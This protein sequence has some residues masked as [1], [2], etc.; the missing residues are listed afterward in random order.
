MKNAKTVRLKSK[1][2]N[3]Q[4]PKSH[5]WVLMDALVQGCASYDDSIDLSAFRGAIRERSTDKLFDA[6]DRWGPQCIAFSDG[7]TPDLFSVKYQLSAFLKKFPFPG[8]SD[9]RTATALKG[10]MEAE[11][12]CGDYNRIARKSFAAFS[13]QDEIMQS[14]V[15]IMRDFIRRVLGDSVELTAVTEFARHGPG[16][17]FVTR[18]GRVT[19]Y[20][21]YSDLPYTVT[22]D[23]QAYARLLIENDERWYGALQDRYRNDNGIPIWAPISDDHLFGWA[24]EVIPGNRITF[25]PKD[26]RKDRPIAIEPLMNLM[27]QLG[28]DG[29]LRKRLKR[30]G[31]NLDSQRKNQE[32]ALLGSLPGSELRFSTID[33]S[34]ASDSVSKELC[35]ELLPAEWFSYLM[36]LRSP[37]GTVT[38]SEP[39]SLVYEK[40]SSMGNGFTF[41]LES[42]IF[43]AVAYAAT[44]LSQSH[45]VSMHDISVYGDDIIVPQHAAL[46]CIELLQRC[47][48]STNVDKTY[49]VGP[50][51][52]SCGMDYFRGV[53]VRPLF[54]T[55][56]IKDVKTLFSVTN[57]LAFTS[58]RVFG[59]DSHP[60]LQRAIEICQG[61]IPSR[62]KHF[63]GP[64]SDTEF[65]TYLHTPVSRRSKGKFKYHRG[66]Y[67]FRR[68]IVLPI[69]HSRH[70]KEFLFR[71]LMANLRDYEVAIPEWFYRVDPK[72]WILLDDISRQRNHSWERKVW[73]PR[74]SGGS[75]FT[76]T[77]RNALTVAHVEST[78]S[79]WMENYSDV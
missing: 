51:R 46:L 70:A 53:L 38:V 13:D 31:C 12:A 41:A 37:V 63:E 64:P 71:K 17:S 3:V 67:H 76:V 60:L 16:S 72:L 4:V 10:F 22:E 39:F 56:E 7:M 42:L 21:K 55:T 68:L 30:F 34:A 43:L 61:W 77:K 49:V 11:A 18:D 14:A 58:H 48:F 45:D 1:D 24:F 36:D 29:Y 27:L 32:L 8:D 50:F 5:P 65:D 15:P 40:I 79:H 28:V 33:L 6:I 59:T 20:F 26:A 25:V 19:E 73:D 57:R 52:E 9:R 44:K 2:L 74:A 47:G 62:W 23:C 35:R 75:R 69:D 54:L 78:S 66:V